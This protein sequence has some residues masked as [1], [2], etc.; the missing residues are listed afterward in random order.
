MFQV[1][2]FPSQGAV[3]RGRYYAQAAPGAPT[4]VMTHGT[5]AT[6]TMVVDVYAEALCRA[7]FNVLLY[8]HR[9]FGASDGEPRYEINPWVQGRSYR[10]AVAFLRSQLG[11]T[12]IALWGDSYTG[13]VVLVVG[14][15]ID[16]ISAI[17]AQIPATGMQLPEVQ[18]SKAALDTLR[19]IFA[20]GDIAGG[21]E[22]T[23]GPMPVVS[24]DQMNLPS[25]LQP[26][27]AYRWFIEYGGRFG[28]NWQ[29][30]VTRVIPPTPVPFNAYLTAPYLKAPT[31]ML[32]GRN[33][34]MVHCNRSVQQAV[35]A[36]ITAPK[37]FYEIDGGHFGLLW[38][39]GALFDESVKCQVG[40]LRETL[41][42]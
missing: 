28:T 21:P 20:T 15:L 34:E 31:L 35:F 36:A 29:N 24:P 17:I 11:A 5:S 12:R 4:L 16:D 10:D 38:H 26:I 19:S 3:L 37:K 8:D 30:R 40:F 7:G 1:V 6:I 42:L 18:P 22:H 41:G 33:D 39:P 23:T 9:N 27:Q 13:M 2:E 25:L 32:V 14:A